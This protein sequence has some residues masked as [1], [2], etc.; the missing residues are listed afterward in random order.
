MQIIEGIAIIDDVFSEDYCNNLI[1]LFENNQKKH[2]IGETFAG[3]NPSTKTTKE[4]DLNNFSDFCNNSFAE[5]LNT[6]LVQYLEEYSS[7]IVGNRWEVNHLFNVSTA[8]HFFKMQKYKKKE[9]H[10][11][12]LHQERDAQFGGKD[13]VFTFMLYLND[14]GEGGVTNFPLQKK[15]VKPKCGTLV[16]WPAGFPYLHNGE[17]PISNN[18]YIIT[19][20]LEYVYE[21]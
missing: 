15:S 7:D 10:Y 19:T 12:A 14:V 3:I 20:W 11:I 21:K 4:I 2:F 13:R 5:I 8:Y 9:G 17:M 1:S 16:I 18:K 6:N